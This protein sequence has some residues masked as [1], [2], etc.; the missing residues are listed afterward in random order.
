MKITGIIKSLTV[1]SCLFTFV[2]TAWSVDLSASGKSAQG[3]VGDEAVVSKIDRDKITLRSAIDANKEITV[4]MNNP[5]DLKVGD[6]V[7]VQG[8]II[9][10]LDAISDTGAQP[11]TGSRSGP[12]ETK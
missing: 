2:V 11:E 12:A 9:K 4:S 8:N 6:K 7:K 10:K 3:T 5:G 1:I